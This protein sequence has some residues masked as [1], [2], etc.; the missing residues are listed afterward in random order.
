M[1]QLQEEGEQGHEGQGDQHQLADGAGGGVGLNGAPA[2][3]PAGMVQAP[4][5]LA[6]HGDQLAGQG[7][8]GALLGGQGVGALGVGGVVAQQGGQP[9]NALTIGML[10]LTLKSLT[11]QTAVLNH[12]KQD[13]AVKVGTQTNPM[14]KRAIE[15]DLR[16]LDCLEDIRSYLL[17]NGSP[18]LVTP[19]NIELVNQAIGLVLAMTETMKSKISANSDKH[20]IARI[21]ALGWK[22]V[23]GIEELEGDLSGI[24][25]VDLRSKETAYMKHLAAVAVTTKS[26]VSTAATSK[27][28]AKWKKNKGKKPAG[29]QNRGSG[30][31]NLGKKKGGGVSKKPKTGGCHRCGGAHFV[32]N[33]DKPL[34]A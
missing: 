14:S 15:H 12:A 6:G 9:I 31:S 27:G 25:M 7:G 24:S 16:L 28:A 30:D 20:T 19:H 29:S 3:A 10:S 18:V 1:D 8:Q 5:I 11:E 21:S 32:R 13:I 23:S 22:L 33:C 17:V 4:P 34:A 2:P 26:V